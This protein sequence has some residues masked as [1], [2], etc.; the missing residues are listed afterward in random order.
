[1]IVLETTRRTTKLELTPT[2]KRL[3]KNGHRVVTLHEL[4]HEAFHYL[5]ARRSMTPQQ[6]FNFMFSRH[7]TFGFV[8]MLQRHRIRR[9]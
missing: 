4:Y 9:S 7:D 3:M 2:D 5:Q 6:A 8:C 1:M